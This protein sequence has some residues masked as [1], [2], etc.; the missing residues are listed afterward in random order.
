MVLSLEFKI[1]N[2]KDTNFPPKISYK[3]HAINNY[4]FN[5]D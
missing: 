2:E 4:I 3:K 1:L 5:K